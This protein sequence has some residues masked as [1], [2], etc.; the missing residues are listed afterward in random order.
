MIHTMTLR[1]FVLAAFTILTATVFASGQAHTK[2]SALSLGKVRTAIQVSS[3]PDGERIQAIQ[4]LGHP[5]SIERGQTMVRVLFQL[6][7]IEDTLIVLSHGGSIR[8]CFGT[9]ISAVV[10]ADA[11]DALCM[12]QGILR[13][14]LS[15]LL[16][17]SLNESVKEIRADKVHLG[18][19]LPTAYSGKNVIIGVFDTGIDVAHPDFR[20]STGSR[21]LSLWDMSDNNGTPPTGFSW[22]REYS[23]TQ[24]D[25]GASAVAERDLDGHG[26]HV[27][28]TAA[29]NG[30]G[31]A[32][33]VGVAPE[34]DIIVVKGVRSDATSN[35][36]D[37]DIVAGCQYIF[38]R[39]TALGK[40][41]VIN[42]SLGGIVGPHDGSELTVQVLNALVEPGH[43]IVA[44]AGNE[45]SVPIHAGGEITATTS[46]EALI[47][48]INVCYL[49]EGFCPPDPNYFMTAAD[50]W[51]T[52]GSVDTLLVGVYAPDSTG[53]KLSKVLSFP[54]GVDV[55]DQE[56]TLNGVTIG[57]IS[58][59]TS[60]RS[61]PNGAGNLILQISNKGRT[62]V[63]VENQLWGLSFRGASN[64]RVDLWAGVPIPENFAIIGSLGATI[65]GNSQMT[66]GTPATGQNILSVGSYVTKNEWTSLVGPQS[67]QGTT[68]TALSG[69]SSQGPTRD[70]RMA[71]IIAAPGE[72][73][74]AAMTSAWKPGDD[75][76]DSTMI[77]PGGLYTGK[78]GTSM[79]T[80]HVVGVIALMMEAMPNLTLERIKQVFD[81]TARHD[82]NNPE[83][84][85]EMGFGKIDA[86]SA[87]ELVTT[88]I[89]QSENTAPLQLYPNPANDRLSISAAYAYHSMEIVNSMG[90]VIAFTTMAAT[91]MYVWSVPTTSL[92]TGRYMVR[93]ISPS[94]TASVPLTILH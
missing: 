27:A 35:F 57:F 44:A 48:P 75:N 24:L 56:V 80:P 47:N 42:L 32:D 38:Q 28:G 72:V 82:N 9:V 73:I 93:L 81:R 63:Q 84:N 7:R 18:E 17:P 67:E 69:F 68:L 46:L 74:F 2:L 43:I 39:A 71:P 64:G 25:A 45:G 12:D 53:M 65:Y 70:G 79:A 11:L 60:T 83:D 6:S 85:N 91:G 58:A 94:S 33:Y 61:L 76:Y 89:A 59:I 50:V 13:A 3:K 49:F 29:G 92:P 37:D 30:G 26:T 16:R 90:Q 31:N 40:Q 10:P 21:I 36:A 66:I 55:Q 54:I 1:S 87:C 5:F 4:A 22:G 15:T 41:A 23:K 20:T 78:S 62:D 86:W 8:H 34:A 77:A 14:Q 88:A 52:T 51:Y 19:G